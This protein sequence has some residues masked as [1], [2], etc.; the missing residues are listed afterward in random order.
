MAK[1][2]GIQ[3]RRFRWTPWVNLSAAL[4]ACKC[5]FVTP[6]HQFPTTVT[7]PQERKLA[8]LELTRA[9]GQFII[10]DDYESD[11]S[12]NRTPPR[13]LKSLD[14]WG[15][16]IYTGS[17]SK[18]LLPGLRLGYLVADPEFIREARALR[19]YMLRHPR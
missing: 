5:L 7:M 15:N 1:I 10:E 3:V 18:S 6:S 2:E 14:R 9:N 4:E 13:A 17:L 12:F 19:H 16:V 11:V 8:L